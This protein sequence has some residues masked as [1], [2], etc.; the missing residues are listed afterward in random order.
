MLQYVK[1]KETKFPNKFWV[2]IINKYKKK[3][4]K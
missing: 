1:Q 4:K 3:Y 2:I